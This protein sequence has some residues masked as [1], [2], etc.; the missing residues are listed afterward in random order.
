[1]GPRFCPSCFHST[2][3]NKTGSDRLLRPAAPLFFRKFAAMRQ[4]RPTST[5]RHVVREFRAPRFS[6]RT[7]LRPRRL[8][9][10][11]HRSLRELQR[12]TGAQTELRLAAHV[13][14]TTATKPARAERVGENRDCGRPQ[15]FPA[16]D[17]VGRTT[18]A[19]GKP[20][21]PDSAGN[22]RTREEARRASQ[23]PAG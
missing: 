12:K 10:F 22:G 17:I 2:G 11:F 7:A 21:Y 9:G 1:M 20:L 23:L 5:E 13:R 3:I 6:L 8:C 4:S 14:C 16:G 15:V 19:C 18:P